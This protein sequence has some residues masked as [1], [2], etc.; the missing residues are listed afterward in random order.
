MNVI[1]TFI[2]LFIS[3]FTA[4]THAIISSDTLLDTKTLNPFWRKTGRRVLTRTFVSVAL[5]IS[6]SRREGV[7]AEDPGPGVSG[8]GVRATPTVSTS[9]TEEVEGGSSRC[10]GLLLRSQF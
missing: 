9:D 6:H 2:L 3:V 8:I 1:F 10:S 4:R 5:P 7:G